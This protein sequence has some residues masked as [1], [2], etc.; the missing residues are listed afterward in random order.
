MFQVV[1]EWSSRLRPRRTLRG[2][3]VLELLDELQIGK[4]YV[5]GHS[6]GG[7]H[8]MQV[9]A[10]APDRVLGCAVTGRISDQ[11]LF[12]GSVAGQSVYV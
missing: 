12:R 2:S 3:E 11:P 10:A 1:F 8:A 6:R 4:F 9:A 7:C 5:C